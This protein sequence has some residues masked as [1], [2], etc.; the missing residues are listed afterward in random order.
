MEGNEKGTEYLLSA[1]LEKQPKSWWLGL[2]SYHQLVWIV[3]FQSLAGENVLEGVCIYR[4]A[5]IC[6]YDMLMHILIDFAN[7][8]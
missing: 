2:N 5:L 1:D 6:T 3:L 7:V 4:L 8:A